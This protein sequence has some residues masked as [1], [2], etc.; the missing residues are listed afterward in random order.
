MYP[1]CT[2]RLLATTLVLFL[3][4]PARG[5]PLHVRRQHGADG[6]DQTHTDRYGDPLPRGATARFGSLRWRMEG[7][8]DAVAVSP[9]GKLVASVNMHGQVAV[10]DMASGRQLHQLTGA[11]SG[12]GC[13]AFS[14]NGKYLATGGRSDSTTGSG[15][16]RV[17]VWEVSTG[18]QKASFPRQQGSIRDLAFSPDGAAL[19]SSGLKQPVIAWMFPG[20][21]KLREFP[22]KTKP[23]CIAHFVLSPNGRWL[24]LTDDDKTVRVYAFARGRKQCQ[25]RTRTYIYEG[26]LQFSPDSRSLMTVETDKLRFWDVHTGKP[27]FTITLKYDLWRRVHLSPEGKKLALTAVDRDIHWLDASTGKPL[28]SWIGHLDKVSSLAFSRDGRT[29]VTG[30]WGVVRVWDAATG[31]VVRE[32]TGPNRACYSLVFSSDGKTLLA[33]ST[34]LHFLDGRTLQERSRAPLAMDWDLGQGWR[35]SFALSPDAR[36]AAAVGT[37]GEIF[38]VD[39]RRSQIVRTLRRRG[40]LAKSI[41]FAP[42]GKRLYAVADKAAGL[43]VWDVQT[44]KE[45]APLDKDLMPT[46][47]FARAA[48]TGKLALVV[49]GP[50]ARCRFWDARTGKEEPSLKDAADKI[51]LSRNGKLLAAFHY[52]GPDMVWDVAKQVERRRFNAGLKNWSAW[53]FSADGQLLVTGFSD[54][55]FCTWNLATGKKVAGV[56]GHPGAIAA[57]ACSPDGTALVTACTSCTVLRWE[58]SAWKGK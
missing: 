52:E 3:V 43:R 24:A 15:D 27:R 37:N 42:D 40:W 9:D 57:M 51:L 19:L 23:D 46:S 53:T 55:S 41:A 8:I 56:R 54:G 35:Y 13:L 20:G 16:F 38:L 39:S 1:R 2:C 30:E 6:G 47:E 25:L 28:A 48:G 58:S 45:G 26:G 31:K 29:V 50:K 11:K 21:K 33:G 49:G 44:G 34:D 7:D 14:P 5:D 32:T 12:E 22:T 36:L 4:Q 18:K 17:R 10:W